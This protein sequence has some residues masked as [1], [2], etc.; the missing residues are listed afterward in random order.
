MVVRVKDRSLL[1]D[2]QAISGVVG[3]V[4]VTVRQ[5]ELPRDLSWSSPRTKS[6]LVM[7]PTEVKQRLGGPVWCWKVSIFP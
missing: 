7:R 6:Q 5:E 3:E 1:A 2:E 4:E